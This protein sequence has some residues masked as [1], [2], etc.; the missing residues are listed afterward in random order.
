MTATRAYGYRGGTFVPE[1]HAKWLHELSNPSFQNT[2]AFAGSQTFV[3][4]GLRGAADTFNP[5]LGVT[6]LSCSCTA[7]VWSL[8]GVYDYYW[9]DSA[10]SAQR[11]ML[12]FASRF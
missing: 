10:Y 6:F 3:T 9:T 12:K 1:V 7:S 5:G 2:A 8:E 11:V 4:S